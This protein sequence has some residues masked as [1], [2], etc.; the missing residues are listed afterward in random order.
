MA[1]RNIVKIGDELLRKKCR[2]VTSFDSRLESIVDDMTETLK[3]AD[4]CGLA[5]PQVGILRRI[6][7]IDVGDGPIE[8]INPEILRSGGRQREIEGCL[9]CPDSWGYVKRPMKIR[10]RAQDRTGEFVEYEGRELFA[11]CVCHEIDH[12]DGVL[13]VDKADEMVDPADLDEKSGKL[14][15]KKK[16]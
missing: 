7:I 4:G 9:S 6:I 3:K 10:V 12:L 8:L 13:F 5:A 16:R 1:T 2:P 15:K 11:R 14:R